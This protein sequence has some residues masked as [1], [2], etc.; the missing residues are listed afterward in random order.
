MK[1]IALAILICVF[2]LA[3][4][5]GV[6]VLLTP[7]QSK[8]LEF[9][10]LPAVG[11]AVELGGDSL[12]VLDGDEM[13]VVHIPA[14]EG[15]TNIIATDSLFYCSVGNFIC[16]I[17]PDGKEL[18][19]VA[20]LDNDCFTLYPAAG[21][22]FFAV[23]ADDE[24]SS[25]IL[26]DP[27]AEV[28]QPVFDIAAPVFKIEANEAHVFA[29]IG[30]DII[31][32]GANGAMANL[33]SDPTMRDFVLTP[34]GILVASDSGLHLIKSLKEEKT[35]SAQKVARLWYIGGELFA[36]LDDGYLLAVDDF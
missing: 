2:A 17:S 5:A 27:A 8:G 30:N 20:V 29:W 22:S 21:T 16:E 15:A 26:F 12:M 33:L 28:Y 24:F 32:V 31:A 10:N 3:S 1:K 18:K 25:C 11:L 14:C 9:V 4:R 36:L 13:P 19:D 23:T 35:V 34:K 7:E 6:R